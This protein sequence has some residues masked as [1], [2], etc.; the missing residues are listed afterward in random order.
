MDE[1]WKLF[2]MIPG[3]DSIMKY[4]ARTYPGSVLGLD[5]KLFTSSQVKAAK[6]ILNKADVKIKAADEDLIDLIWED[7]PAPVQNPIFC[8]ENQYSGKTAAEKIKIIRE[9][10]DSDVHAFVISMMDE[11]C[12]LLNIRGSDVQFNPVVRAYIILKQD[13]CTLYVDSKQVSN[14]VKTQLEQENV[15]IKD[16]SE[17]FADVELCA[18]AAITDSVSFSK[19][20][21][22]WN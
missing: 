5:A 7:R 20:F 14:Q 1:N 8:L 12:W 10:L 6:E 22:N 4:I 17:I 19:T 11:V 18:Q 3:K 9:K 2:K 15:D 13:S 16:Y 21:V